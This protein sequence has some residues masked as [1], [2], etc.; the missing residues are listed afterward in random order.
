M[1]RVT[2]EDCIVKISNRFE[3]TLLASQRAREISHGVTLTVA[4]DNDKNPVVALREIADGSVR[5]EY[6]S[7]ALIQSMQKH[8]SHRED[9]EKEEKNDMMFL[10][11]IDFSSDPAEEDGAEDIALDE[12]MVEDSLNLQEDVVALEAEAE[13]LAAESLQQGI[14]IETEIN[15][16]SEINNTND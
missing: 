7:N 15:N 3:L 5:V 1:A 4:R 9:E 10:P 11:E 6:L 12:E 8:I 2:V 13:A 16:D 14:V